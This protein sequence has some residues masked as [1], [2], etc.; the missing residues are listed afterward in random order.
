MR[1]LLVAINSK[2]IHPNLAVRYLKANCDFDVE[3]KEF[4]IK[5]DIEYIYNNIVSQ[6]FNLIGFSVYIWNVE[7][8]KLL[9][10]KLSESNPDIIIVLGGPEASYDYEDYLLNYSV[11]FVIRNEG[12]IAFNE[13]LKCL[14]N[15]T[16][17]ESISNLV[18]KDNDT[19]KSNA[20]SEIKTLDDLKNPYSVFEDDYSHRIAYVELSRGCPFHCSYCLASLEKS[21]RF[22]N[23]D[24]VKNDII[25]LYE[26]G[27][28]TFK[29]LDRTFNIREELA[30][31]ILNFIFTNRFEGAVFQFEINADILSNDFV[32]FINAV[33][34]KNKIR[35]EIG[36][37]SINDKVNQAVKRRQDTDVLLKN[38]ESLKK[39]NVIMHLDLI[40]GLPYENLDSFIHTFDT[41]YR[42]YGDELQ[43][44]FL[45]LLKGTEL[46]QQKSQYDYI[47]S[48]IAPY[49]FQ[50]NH[51]I[52]EADLDKIKLV[53]A[54]LNIFWNKRFMPISMTLATKE[55]DSPFV[56][57]Y[58]L[59]KAF[60]ASGLDFHRYQLHE[61]FLLFENYLNSDSIRDEIRLEYLSR[62][63]IKPKIY[64][65]KSAS[66]NDTIREYHSLNPAL[67]IDNFYKYGVVID[68]HGS[69]LIYVYYPKEPRYYLFG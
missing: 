65:E 61:V 33:T 21:V 52:S 55:V 40:A 4:T 48:S 17:F 9:L 59:G 54:V 15:N 14:S 63:Q 11:D 10:K 27:A 28:R 3:V 30:R 7:I 12:E 2:F 29:F 68:Y 18:Y 53:E 32:E 37:Q 16:S 66:K 41:V 43:L 6:S 35:F 13:L 69:K 51:F 46:N 19:I 57:L 62:H 36:I 31:D 44:G 26:K 64:W 45:K 8:V 47:V 38:I 67:N 5:D 23:T 42:L 56:F 60:I 1:S 58:N 34:P 25:V 39:G 22:F 50:S 20:L 24:R 49:E